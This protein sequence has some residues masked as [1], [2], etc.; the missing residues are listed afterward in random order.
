[1]KFLQILFLTSVSA[2]HAQAQNNFKYV[3]EK[4]NRYEFDSL[5]Y[6]GIMYEYEGERVW[7]TDCIFFEEN[8]ITRNIDTFMLLKGGKKWF[9]KQNGT[10]EL[11][12]SRSLFNRKKITQFS[13]SKFKP[14]EKIRNGKHISFLFEINSV[15]GKECEDRCVK[16]LFDE[17]NGFTK[18]IYKEF[19][20]IR[21]W[22]L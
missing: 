22:D 13:V 10:W 1:M 19:T 2:F 12:Y 3:V 4:P 16:I 8:V 18:I 20:L 14:L 9:V 15:Y 7:I 17:K 6:D 5:L 21:V 11:F